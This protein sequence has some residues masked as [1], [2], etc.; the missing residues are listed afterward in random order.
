VTTISG[1]Y[2]NLYP[3][4]QTGSPTAVMIQK[5][6]DRNASGGMTREEILEAMASSKPFELRLRSLEENGLLSGSSGARALSGPGRLLAAFILFYRRL[7]KL[8]LGMG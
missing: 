7:L 5:I 2:V 1:V 3:L 8:P 4:F 6:A